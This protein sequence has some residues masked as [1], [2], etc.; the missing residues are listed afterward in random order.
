MTRQQLQEFARVGAEAKLAALRAEREELLALFPEL[1]DARRSGA[2]GGRTPDAARD[3]RGP[4]QGRGYA[5][6]SLLGEAEGGEE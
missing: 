1:R 4:A 5:D 6:A 2:G 3:V